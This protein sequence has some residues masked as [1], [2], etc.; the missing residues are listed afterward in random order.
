MKSALRVSPWHSDVTPGQHCC[1]LPYFVFRPTLSHWTNC[2]HFVEPKSSLPC[3]QQRATCLCHE[4]DQ[5][6]SFENVNLVYLWLQLSRYSDSLQ[7]GRSGD[8]IPVGARFSAPVQTGPGVHPASCT[9]G[10]GSF[11]G[12]K[13]PEA[14][15]WPSTSSGDVKEYSYTS[16]P[17]CAF[18]ACCRVTFTFSVGLHCL[19]HAVSQMGTAVL[20]SLTF[21]NHPGWYHCFELSWLVLTNRDQTT[22]LIIIV[23]IIKINF[24]A[25]YACSVCP[26]LSIPVLHNC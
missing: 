26:I 3:S 4:P 12:V 7:A 17:L 13:L 21:R 25:F 22:W 9:M 18:M 20:C 19:K 2:P 23:I 5:S 16:T 6:N 1:L 10:S 14:W 11:P 15:R 24:P 8:R